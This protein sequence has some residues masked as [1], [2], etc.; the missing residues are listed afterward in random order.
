MPTE[1][2]AVDDWPSKPEIQQGP[3]AEYLAALASLQ[4]QPPNNIYPL[5]VGVDQRTAQN[6]RAWLNTRQNVTAKTTSR[7][8]ELKRYTEQLQ[9]KGF[10]VDFTKLEAP[11]NHIV[12]AQYE[13]PTT[14]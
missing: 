10:N 7:K 2:P 3:K 5:A 11:N 12:L 6:L 4:S 13:Q 9:A 8:S 14:E 1:L